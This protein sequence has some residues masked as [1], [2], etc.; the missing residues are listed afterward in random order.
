MKYDV[1][2]IEREYASGGREIGRAVA[3]ELGIPCYGREILQLAAE[4][5]GASPEYM[6]GL[7]ERPTNSLLYTL[8]LMSRMSSMEREGATTE[9]KLHL[10]EIE[11]IRE[12][13]ARGNCVL[14]GRRAGAVLGER[15]NALRVFVYADF[16][17]RRRRAT[18]V[19]RDDPKQVEAVLR[20]AD[21]RRVAYYNSYM[22]QTWDDRGNYHLMLDSGKLGL[23]GSVKLIVQAARG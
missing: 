1:I 13:G 21:K 23:D 7:E 18:E 3:A 10:A 19:Y 20:R 11:V 22:E 4:R 15:R 5:I 9:A 12:L 8:S 2:T 6:E 16:E 14:V 17:A